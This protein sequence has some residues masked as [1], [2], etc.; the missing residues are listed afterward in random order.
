M[1]TFFYIIMCVVLIYIILNFYYSSGYLILFIWFAKNI[2]KKSKIIFGDR[3][4]YF[5]MC[6][7]PNDYLTIIIILSYTRKL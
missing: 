6:V 3:I 4:L 1:N 2:F 5:K 7:S